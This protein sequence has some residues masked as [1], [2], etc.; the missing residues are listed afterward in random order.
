VAA[1][2]GGEEGRKERTKSLPP[3]PNRTS[4]RRWRDL[5]EEVENTKKRNLLLGER[6][7]LFESTTKHLPCMIDILD[8][9]T[10]F[11]IVF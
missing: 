6:R 4:Q 5:I 10:S 7:E 9:S 2:G 1:L 3:P 11:A 8:L